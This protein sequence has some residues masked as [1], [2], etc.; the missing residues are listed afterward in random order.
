MQKQVMIFLWMIMF[1]CLVGCSS[2][3]NGV[4]QKNNVDNTDEMVM[5][6]QVEKVMKIDQNKEEIDQNKEERAGEGKKEGKQKGVQEE[7]EKYGKI[8]EKEEEVKVKPQLTM[9]ELFSLVKERRLNWTDFEPYA[10]KDIGFGLYILMYPIDDDFCLLIGGSGQGEPM[11][12]RVY[13]WDLE[14]YFELGKN[15]DGIEESRGLERFIQEKRE[16]PYYISIAA[17]VKE[18]NM[19]NCQDRI[20]ISSDTDAYPGVFWVLNIQE[21]MGNDDLQKLK[22]GVSINILMKKMNQG[23]KIEGI[24]VYKAKDMIC[25]S[26][27][28]E[29]ASGEEDILLTSA[30]ELVLGDLLSSQLSSFAVKPG[31]FTWTV[32]E[33]KGEQQ[34]I[35]CGAAPLDEAGVHW[36]EKL[37]IPSYSADRTLYH[38]STKIMPDSLVLRQ[39]DISDKGKDE[40]KEELIVAYYD[41]MGFVELQKG[42]VYELNAEWMKENYQKNN[43]YG[44]ASY[45]FVTE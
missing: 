11:Y 36:K 29:G 19:D 16:V 2:Q 7:G 10:S 4:W 12:M 38:Y 33:D 15:L 26:D 23:Y 41:K 37:K 8:A 27:D 45:V 31:S 1:V 18:V 20:L 13:L 44:T 5:E 28:E 24:P 6:T 17:H 3:D 34:M 35:A 9:E 22:G 25:F 30:P 42:K 14:E 32:K 39:W 40:A 21:A 43:F